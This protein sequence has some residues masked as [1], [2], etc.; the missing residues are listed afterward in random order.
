MPACARTSRRRRLFRVRTGRWIG[1]ARVNP[2]DRRDEAIPPPRERL[3]EDGRL[4]GIVEG[5]PDVRDAEVEAA[6]EI[7]ERAVIP[8]P[9]AER[10]A[11]HDLAG[12]LQQ[13]RQHACR[14]RLEPDGPTL[15]GERQA[16]GV[17]LEAA[18]S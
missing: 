16:R 4:G 1:R 13:H 15:A 9:L 12:L 5:R 7:D 17:E 14:L 8:D 11:R 18:E 6:L 3:D 2:V 10:V